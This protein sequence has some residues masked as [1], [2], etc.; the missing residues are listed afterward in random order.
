MKKTYVLSILMILSSLLQ[1]QVFLNESFEGETYP[2]E[3]WQ[4]EKSQGNTKG[5]QLTESGNHSIST[6]HTGTYFAEFESCVTYKGKTAHLYTPLLDLTQSIKILSFYTV[7]TPKSNGL[8]VDVSNDG[9]QTW[10]TDVLNIENSANESDWTAHTL[11]LSAYSTSNKVQIRFWASSSWSS[12]QCNIAIDDISG[13]ALYI[14]QEPPLATTVLLP[15]DE[16]TGMDKQIQLSW[17]KADYAKGYKMYLGTDAAATNIINGKDLGKVTTFPATKLAFATTYYWKVAPYNDYGETSQVPVWSFTVKDDP[18]I[19]TFP[20]FEGFE[21]TQFPPIGWQTTSNH[22]KYGWS[23]NNG[24]SNGP[25]NVPEGKKAAMAKVTYMSNGKIATLTTPPLAISTL[26]SPQ[27][28]FWWQ[29]EK[30]SDPDANLTVNISVDN[31]LT[32]TEIYN[33]DADGSVDQWTEV[34]LDLTGATD[35]TLIQFKATSDYGSNNLFLDQIKVFEPSPMQYVSSTTE[36]CNTDLLSIGTTNNQIIRLKIITKGAKDKLHASA[37]TFSTNGTTDPADIT[38]AKVYYT[39][40]SEEFST[41]TQFGNFSLPNGSFKIEGSQELMEGKNYFWLTYDINSDAIQDHVVDAECT[42]VS[43]GTENET[44]TITAPEGNRILKRMLNMPSGKNT[45][46]VKENLLFY[47]NGGEANKYSDDFEGTITF[48]P[49]D[50]NRKIQIDWSSFEIFQNKSITRTNDIFKVFN[51]NTTNEDILI[52]KYYGK[53]SQYYSGPKNLPSKIISSAPDGSLTIYFKVN[54]GTPWSGWVADV[55]EIVPQNMVYVSSDAVHPSTEI[56]AAGDQNTQMLRLEVVTENTLNTLTVS[57]IKL[58]LGETTAA[59][60]IAKANIFYSGNSKE[61]SDATL[62]GSVDNP[63]SEFEI[64]QDQ[65]LKYGKNYFWVT[66]DIAIL[67]ANGNKVD[68]VCNAIVIDKKEKTPSNTSPEGN[69]VIDNTYHM[70]KSGTHTKTVYT[71]FDFTDDNE[72][73][74]GKYTYNAKGTV[75]FEPA[76]A[77]EKVKIT[78]SSF[79]LYFSSYSYGTKAKF[80]VYNGR[81]KT[82]DN[83]LY[84]TQAEDCETGPG[85]PICSTTEDGCLTVCFEGKASS[86]SHTKNGWEA[87]VKTYIPSPMVYKET[88]LTQNTDIIR[89]GSNDQLILGAIVKTEGALN[90]FKNLQLNFSTNGSTSPADIA[91][92]KLY[93]TGRSNQFATTTQVGETIVDP[94]GTFSFDY[95]QTL[96]EGNNY[97]WLVYDVKANA[98]PGNVLDAQCL[99]VEINEETHTLENP[100]PEGNRPIKK[101]YN[102]EAGVNQVTVNQFSTMFYD[103]GGISEKYSKKFNG[104]VT[105]IPEDI[106]HKV[107]LTISKLDINDGPKLY[108]YNGGKVSDDALLKKMDDDENINKTDQPYFFKSSTD[109]GKLT[110]K[111][112]SPSYGSAKTGWEADVKSFV[113][114]PIHFESATDSQPETGKVLKSEKET[115]ILQLAVGFKGEIQP[116]KVESITFTTEGTTLDSDIATAS[117]FYTGTSEEFNLAGATKFG[118]TVLAPS[119]EFTITGDIKIAAEETYYFWLVYDITKSA[120]PGNIVNGQC[121]NISI[122]GDIHTLQPGETTPGRQIQTGFHGEYTI[123]ETGD[124]TSFSTAVE[125]LKNG[126]DGPVTFNVESGV[127]LEQVKIPAIQGT[128]TDNTI[129]FKSET[130]NADDVTLIYNRY[131]DPGY[132]KPKYGVLTFEGG[133]Y[134]HFENMTI[135]TTNKSMVALVYIRDV[136][137]D[138]VFKGNKLIAPNSTSISG[139]C[140]VSTK[141]KNEANKNNDRLSFINNLVSGGYN[142]ISIWGTGYTRLPKEKGH[143]IQGNRFEKQH[144][145]ALWFSDITDGTIQ[146]NMVV[147]NSTTKSDFNALTIRNPKGKTIVSNNIIRLDVSIEEAKGIYLQKAVGNENDELMVFNNIVNISSSNKNA[148]GISISSAEHIGIYH[149]TIKITG[150]GIGKAAFVLNYPV[151]SVNM[152]NNILI[153]EG[154]APALV[155]NSENKLDQCHLDYNNL[156]SEGILVKGYKQVQYENLAAWKAIGKGAHSISEEVVFYSETDLHIKAKGNLNTG[157]SG[158]LITEDI[159]GDERNTEHPTMGADE[160]QAASTTAPVFAE[161]YPKVVMTNH[162]SAQLAAQT[163][164]NG[165]LYFVTLNKDA[166]TP[167]VAQVKAG[168]NAANTAL[169]AGMAG[170]IEINK[171]R[172]ETFSITNLTDHTQYDAYLVAEDNLGNCME[173]PV[174]CAFATTHKITEPSSFETL[175]EGTTSFNDGTAHFEGFTVTKGEGVESSLQYANVAA[176]TAATVSILNTEEGLI[177]NGFFIK[178]ASQ[179]QITGKLKDGSNTTS[180][181]VL[182]SD[183]WTYVDMRELGSIVGVEFAANASGYAIDN[184]SGMPLPLQVNMPDELSVNEGE[185]IQ[186]SPVVSG[187][188][189]PYQY[190]WSPANA[191]SNATILNPEASPVTTT[192]YTIE[193]TDKYGSE[194]SDQV[195]VNVTSSVTKTADFEEIALTPESYL[196]GDPEQESSFFYS[197]SYKFSNFYQPNNYSWKGFGISNETSTTFDPSEYLTQQFRNAA[198]GDVN[199]EGNYAV[200]YACNYVPEIHLNNG[201]TK[202]NVKGMYITNSVYTLYSM[203]NGDSYVGG[204]FTQGD[205][206]MVTVTGY[207]N[208]GTITNSKDIYLADYRSTNPDK[209]FMLKEWK[210]IDL[211]S[212]GKVKTIRFIVSGSRNNDQGLTTPAYFCID[213]FNGEKIDFAPE[214]NHPIA[215]MDLV[216]TTEDKLIDLSQLFTDPDNDDALIEISIKEQSNPDLLTAVIE[217]RKLRLSFVPNA[218]GKTQITLKGT[219]NGKSV[220]TSFTVTVNTATGINEVKQMQMKLYPNPCQDYLWLEMDNYNGEVFIS[221]VNIAGNVVMQKQFH[222]ISKEKLDMSG[223]PAGTYLIQLQT[224]DGNMVKQVLKR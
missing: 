182:P 134:F 161:G 51:G 183:S 141:A 209:H 35:Q 119:G 3:R 74:G 21:A 84:K 83:L 73:T 213:N 164:Q 72:G 113:Q 98:T 76:N 169:E 97:F 177:L 34:Q 92:A 7:V 190:Q 107:R 81:E 28:K 212:L 91:S 189:K 79:A 202:D 205:Y 75:T 215:N 41:T 94:N 118:E 157:T 211:S 120:T 62:F 181:N 36:Q 216:N 101:I 13:P 167:S 117:V 186:L 112:T 217:N 124:Y 80:E 140:C 146:G 69:R 52:G 67:A 148:S 171:D 68:A 187:G 173:A 102:M 222:N 6:P 162:Y 9:G 160:Y 27:L 1:A 82:T 17:N 49:S 180:I 54:T 88:L 128:S 115:N 86:S 152:K 154:Q 95:S 87:Q 57:K 168:T 77:G 85:A 174:K 19:R 195:L 70:P 106:T 131:I 163:D 56:V 39:G 108:I 150:S 15:A 55:S 50:P 194:I 4:H 26:N 25:G 121:K 40:K 78:F 48:V 204:E 20:W 188:V 109:D 46:T 142:G 221:V 32:F 93:T 90:P 23:S 214:V 218:L 208:N 155:V 43:F 45:C 10:T 156:Y 153:S 31:G 18:T 199:H 130:G 184:F 44:P 191:L 172:E 22:N 129:T 116:A 203:E 71:P 135:K 151:Q 158:L 114:Q 201:A 138:L 144:S 58:G 139:V 192:A 206:Y 14:P 137:T 123:G 30:D 176:N 63:A 111:F 12:G 47:D 11:D 136:S 65:A 122:N 37:I 64:Q 147:N 24:T 196:I 103:N 200:V 105:F 133:D 198:G 224:T 2:P 8:H 170:S 42:S 59:S 33:Q 223:L 197:G 110:V 89:A 61:F 125:A 143:L 185:S 219:S 220:E 104:V 210:W 145:K 127:Y 100:S 178:S 29:C 175:A 126:V 66:Y 5:W 149:N 53:E 60:D 166:A 16:S 38:N 179:L 132:D 207:D 193:I 99:D 159:D 165:K 96:M